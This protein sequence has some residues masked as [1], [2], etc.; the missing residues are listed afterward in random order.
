MTVDKQKSLREQSPGSFYFPSKEDKAM[1]HMIVDI[2]IIDN[3]PIEQSPSYQFIE[4]TYGKFE[5]AKLVRREVVPPVEH[6]AK[7]PG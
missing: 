4:Q 3:R 2:C 5:A 7:Q 6:S 1:I